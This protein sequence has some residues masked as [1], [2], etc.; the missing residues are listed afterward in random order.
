MAS[1]S[2][3]NHWWQNWS[4]THAY[5]A[6]RMFFPRTADDITWA[7]QWAEN[8][9]RPIRA[10]GGGWSF[11]DASLP[12][13]V[14]TNRPDVHGVEAM[15]EVVP[16][17]VTFPLPSAIPSPSIASIPPGMRAPDGPRS[18][19]MVLE[20]VTQETNV[21]LWAYA[22]GGTWKY[23]TGWSYAPT[24]P[25]TLKYFAD[26]GVRP[27][28]TL[29]P[30]EL[31][32]DADVAG[33]LVMFDMSLTP[34]APSRD[35]LYNGKGIW[36][37]GVA[38]DSPFDQGDLATLLKNG[39]VGP[40]A[41][42]VSPRAAGPGEALSLV[43]SRHGNVPKLPEPVFLV[44]TRLLAASLQD[45]L[46]EI[47][48]AS[49][50][51]ATA[52]TQ[53]VGGRTFYAHV[54]AG[55]TIQ[56]LGDLL[57]HQSP[58][59]SLLAISG[60]PGAT[61]AG[62]LA[63]ATHGAEFEW[64]LLIDT[65]KAVHLV[66][67]GGVHWWIEGDTPIA[68]P[69]KLQQV[70][71][72]I[73]A[74][75][76][77]AGTTPVAGITPQDWLNAAI[78]SMGSMGV[79]Y[80]MVLQVVPQF[81]VHE[82]VVQKT[83]EDDIW[84]AL[85]QD[86]VFDPALQGL[87]FGNKLRFEKTAKA[88]STGML[89]Y[90][91]DG[92]RN[93]TGIKRANNRYCDLAINPNRNRDGDYECWI[94]NR[95]LMD[96]LPIDPQPP[97]G[98]ETGSMLGSISKAF[99]DPDTLQKLRNI[100]RLGN[101]WDIVFNS[102]PTFNALSRIGSASDMIDVGLDAFLTPMIGNSDGREVAEALLTGILSG[103]LG[104]ANGNKRSDKIG[105]SVGALGFPAGGIMGTALEI[106]LAPADAFTFLQ[107][108][109]LDKVDAA[110][111]F[112]GYVSIR[113]CRQTNTLM[114]MQ[115]FGDPVR[116]YSVMIEVV[117]F[118][119]PN[120][121]QFLRELQD[122]TL[123]LVNTGLDAMLHWGLENDRV[124]GDN[125][126][127]TMGLR[128]P[129]ANPDLSRLD[130]FKAVRGL[131]R[132]VSPATFSV[133]DNAFTARM[134]LNEQVADDDPCSFGTVQLGAR[135]QTK[136]G[137][138][139]RGHAPMRIV[140][141]TVDGDFRMHASYESPSRP[142]NLE[143]GPIP[144]AAVQVDN[145]FELPLTFIPTEAGTHTGTLTI[146]TYADAPYSIRVIRI[147][148]N[149]SVD[150]FVVSLV[151]P[152]PPDA[153]DFGPVDVGDMRTVGV[154]V[155]AGG[156]LGAYLDHYAASDSDGAAQ[157][158]VATIGVGSVPAGQDKTYWVS[159]TPNVAAPLST[160][161]TL[162]FTGGGPF[163]PY[164]QDLVLPVIGSGIGAQAALSPAA[165]DFGT[166]TVNARSASQLITVRNVGQA[167]LLITG[168]ITGS[169][170]LL[171]GPLPASILPG[172]EDQVAVE[173]RPV[174]DGPVSDSFTIQSNSAQPPVP[175]LLSGVGVLEALLRAM[176]ASLRFGTVPVGSQSPG[177]QCVVTNAGVLP[178]VLQ[179][180]AF[181]GPDAVDFMIAANE[182]KA[183]DVLLPEQTCTMS[184]VFGGKVAGPRAATL[185]I[186]HDW[187]NSPFRVPV[188]GLAVDAKG[189]VPLV[190]EV[191]FGDVPVGTTSTPRR[192]T[193]MN[194]SGSVANVGAVAVT[195]K[196]LADFA[197]G[198]DG[199]SGAQLKP[200]DKCTLLV[201][202]APAAMGHK[203]AELSVQ[204]DVPADVVPLRANGLDISVQWS[205]ALVD[206][207]TWAVG[208]TA[209][210]QMVSIH[211]SGNTSVVVTH[212]DV[213]GDFF[214]QDPTAQFPEIRS[215][216]DK[217]L[218]VWFRPTTAGMH[219]GSIT[220][221]TASHGALPSLPLI[222]TAIVP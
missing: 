50:L 116:P 147:A 112:F 127:K 222:G 110:G 63:N 215:N 160:S 19:T 134:W 118:G 173:F 206:F 23:G 45:M 132:A 174:G 131:V 53:P 200:G 179:G 31:K 60:S 143:V 103:L 48:C 34:P 199:C 166:L 204:T 30:G 49:A 105:V 168:G 114:G 24:D 159:Y 6:E 161:L 149:A 44:D 104:T 152:A 33:T 54:E 21:A 79:V 88:A 22:G 100:N 158:G 109:I 12:G 172:Q 150:A 72:E 221:Q 145:F 2:G 138:W 169:G 59:Q 165:L 68:D 43:L 137:P 120:S 154:V 176:P 153:L 151:D 62:A 142:A 181:S 157:L 163:T 205:T 210:R 20:Q 25:A 209:Q 11:S 171:A 196:D 8:A 189:L 84:N 214:I 58:P 37:V 202:A 197:I 3:Q 192:V 16:R 201:V 193:L 156:T 32:D 139:N 191:D 208:Q 38:G 29:L 66:G 218:Y 93:G 57:A 121:I 26:K 91:L 170:F 144:T 107:K 89:D 55:I 113:V 146:V 183:G 67:P 77:I 212:I 216:G 220:I 203:E 96:R 41:P 135:K 194:E 106:A 140:G 4:K 9:Q 128:R 119:T 78:V 73:T 148:L 13:A 136:V 97:A 125:L 27:I 52:R 94:G 177:T 195:G 178:V 95:E 187:P 65:V 28:R 133:F 115:Q 87:E 111:P 99:E 130:T 190:T 123:A 186:A 61:L 217:Y 46:P 5:I 83:W 64:P 180:F 90:L 207:G 185:E 69:V 42:A 35:W 7:I 71:P 102:G 15:A 51:A 182:R 1:I 18:M 155:R 82:V 167:P 36:S 75:R 86:P 122:R 198:K 80:S 10:A 81:G 40:G 162:T 211:N 108:E 92:L 219:Q 98:N 39:R 56:Q 117:A 184:V 14:T 101:L 129:S 213:T 85:N 17:S 141:V 76:I 164:T 126:R 188:D 124:T 175:V 70:Y 47:L 74:E